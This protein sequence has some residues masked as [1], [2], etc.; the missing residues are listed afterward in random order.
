MGFWKHWAAKCDLYPKSQPLPFRTLITY[1]EIL[2]IVLTDA[3]EPDNSV[4]NFSEIPPQI[5]K[6]GMPTFSDFPL[7]VPGLASYQKRLAI[8]LLNLFLRS[9]ARKIELNQELK[10]IPLVHFYFGQFVHWS[11]TAVINRVKVNRKQLLFKRVTKREK[12]LTRG[13]LILWLTWLVI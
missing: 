2:V 5:N 11:E 10:K 7:L 1:T 3:T 9:I 8:K 4:T 12:Q 6:L 13:I